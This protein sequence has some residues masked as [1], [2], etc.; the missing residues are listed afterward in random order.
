M[1][2]ARPPRARRVADGFRYSSDT[3]DRWLSASSELRDDG[4]R[5]SRP[6]RDA[7]RAVPALRPPG[8]QRRRHRGGRGGAARAAHHAGPDGR[9][10]SSEA[11]AEQRRRAPRG[12]LLQRDRGA[13]RR[14]V[15]GRRRRRRRGRHDPD[16]LRRLDRTA[17]STSARRRAS[18]TSTRRPGTS[19]RPLPRRAGASARRRVVPVSFA[20][21]PVDLAPLRVRDRRRRRSRTPAT[22][23]AATATARRSAVPAAPT[24]P[25]SRCTRSR[26]SPPARAAGD[27]RGRRA[28]RR[29]ARVPHPRDHARGRRS[30]SPTRARWYYEHA[31]PRLQ[32]PDHRLPVRARA[33][34]ARPA[35]RLGRAAQRRSPRCYRE[36]LAGDERIALPP[37]APAGS[38]HGYHLFV[39]HVAGGRRG[40]PPRLRRRC[41]PRAS[42]TQVH[43]IPIYRLP[44]LPRHARLRRRT[45]ARTPRP[46]TRGALAADVPGHDR[47]RRPAASRSSELWRRRWP[48][49]HPRAGHALARVAAPARARRRADP[50]WTQ[51]MS[52]S[53]TQWVQGIAPALRRAAPRARIVWDVDGNRYVDFPMA[54]GPVILGHADP[55]V[56]D[57]DRRAARATASPSRCRTRSRSRSPSAIVATACPAPS[58]CASPSPARTR[59]ARRSALARAVTGRDHVLVGGYH[60]WHDWYVGTTSRELGVPAA[61]ARADRHVRLRRPRRAAGAR[62]TRRAATPP[63]SILEPVG[64][65][66]AARPATW[67]A[68]SS[69]RTRAGALVVFDEVITGFRLGARR[70]AGA[71]RRAGRPRRASARRS[72]TACRSRDRRPRGAHGRLRG[73]VL[74]RHPRR[75]GA[76]AG[77][78][79]RDARPASTPPPTRSS[80]APG[81]RLRSGVEASIAAPRRRRLG[82]DRRRGAADARRDPRAGD[83]SPDGACAA[84]SRSCSR[85]CSRAACS[86]T[87]RTSSASPTRDADLDQAAAAYDGALRRLAGGAARRRRRR[88]R[89]AGGP[90][91]H[92]PRSGRSLMS[93]ACPAAGVRDRR[94]ARRRRRALL[95]HRRGGREPQPRPR[96]GARADRRRRAT[97]APTP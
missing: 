18:S 6:W 56:N 82:R 68:S 24:S 76:L 53:P 55:A 50:A 66:R 42:A 14:G 31:G 94:H 91:G 58:A 59:R 84:P 54:L 3:N 8:D 52:K 62:S 61:V 15:R 11:F 9:R 4:R 40:A 43:Y 57:G 77:R 29:A 34:P 5:T 26:R 23:S 46:T 2:D 97:P 73:R 35:G 13:A 41:A 37:A 93:G 90:A 95:R 10:A 1:A 71:L 28:G 78:R 20:G 51:T 81:E 96:P 92:G 27:D 22:R 36:L 32:L 87:A 64:A 74:L 39:V 48:S 63:R 12:R 19:T 69:S 21:L 67:R 44:L 80:V 72:A 47:G 38:L 33:Q 83:P 16:H 85:R 65:T 60:G 70:R 79:A 75:R 49:M 30:P 86:S 89:A 25:A 7:S 45:P 88:A 17:R